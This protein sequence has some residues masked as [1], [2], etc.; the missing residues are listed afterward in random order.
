MSVIDGIVVGVVFFSAIIGFFR[1]ISREIFT[2]ISWAGSIVVAYY[3]HPWSSYFV[4]NHI[5]NPM[6]AD[7]VS[8]LVSFISALVIFSLISHILS[9]LIRSCGALGSVDRALGFGFGVAR[10][11]VILFLCEIAMSCIFSRSER[12]L[13]LQQSRFLPF[14][15][16]GSDTIQN[17]LPIKWRHLVEEQQN[18][19]IIEFQ[20]KIQKMI[21]S[22]ETES[23]DVEGFEKNTP[24]I[25]KNIGYDS[26]NEATKQMTQREVKKN[27]PESQVRNLANLKPKTQTDDSQG[28]RDVDYSVK[29][30]N[31]LDRLLKQTN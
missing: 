1:G 10:G 11:C 22:G 7:G 8:Y 17:L 27:N 5:T 31:N 13:I 9:N 15:Y 29:Q 12:P 24:S 21:P 3:T 2:L 23:G 19:A 18:K 6:L 14:I 25:I 26:I 30:Q 4:K 20:Q 28:K 16:S